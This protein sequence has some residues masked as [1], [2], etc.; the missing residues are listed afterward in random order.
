MTECY[1]ADSSGL[2]YWDVIWRCSAVFV[3]F[4][5]PF[6]ITFINL[7]PTWLSLSSSVSSMLY[8][9]WMIHSVRNFHISICFCLFMYFAVLELELR[10]LGLLGGCSTTWATQPA[11]FCIGYFLGKGLRNYLTG[12]GSNHDL[13]V[14]CHFSS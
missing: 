4:C 11:L 5:V 6:W 13:P 8:G 12:A 14:L 10:A 7:S 3:Y 1:R 9:Q 2:N